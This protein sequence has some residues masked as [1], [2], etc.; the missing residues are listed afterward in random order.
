MCAKYL[1]IRL[2]DKHKILTLN[3]WC[4]KGKINGFVHRM[5]HVSFA[6]VVFERD[7]LQIISRKS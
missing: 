2:V 7:F 1:L 4:V 3:L 5:D 6:E